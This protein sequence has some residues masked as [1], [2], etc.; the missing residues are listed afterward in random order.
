VSGEFYFL[1][2]KPIEHEEH[3]HPRDPDLE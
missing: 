2:R 3:D 1:L